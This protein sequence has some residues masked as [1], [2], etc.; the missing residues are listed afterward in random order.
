M[1]DSNAD[2]TNSEIIEYLD[3]TYDILKN[4]KSSLDL[5]RLKIIIDTLKS[6]KQK[7]YP[8]R[9]KKEN[10]QHTKLIDIFEKY[11]NN[12]ELTEDELKIY[13]KFIENM[14]LISLAHIKNYE[15]LYRLLNNKE[16]KYT[17]EDLSILY[18][19][20]YKERTKQRKKTELLKSILKYIEQ[21]LHFDNMDTRYKKNNNNRQV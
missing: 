21:N 3:I 5:D 8:L 15:E 9:N 10:L 17:I 20:L 1:D 11:E 6:D 19:C 16:N 18:Y 12:K 4:A 2:V 14:P 7:K 13:N